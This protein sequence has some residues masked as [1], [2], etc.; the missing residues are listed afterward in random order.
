MVFL[1]GVDLIDIKGMRSIYQER[2]AEFWVALITAATV[3][4]VGV[5]QGIILAIILSLIVHTRHGYHP[6]DAVMVPSETGTW[7]AQPIAS[8]AQAMPGLLIYRFTHS[9]YYANAEQLSEEIMALVNNAEPPL[10]WFCLDASAV[11]DVDYSAAETLRSISAILKEKGVR[12]VVT[13]VM[14]DVKAESRDR[15]KQ[16]ASEGA[17]F[18]TLE[19][20][21]KAYQQQ[22]GAA[23]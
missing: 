3:V 1:I 22:T 20:V 7:H 5:E 12:L 4:I 18:D 6:K 13:Q 15:L 9:M 19:D 2:R 11:D 23:A 17:V 8:K 14:D 16:L 21:V 10:R